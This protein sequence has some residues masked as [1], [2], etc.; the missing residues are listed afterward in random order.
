MTTERRLFAGLSSLSL[1]DLR[2]GAVGRFAV[3][4]ALLAAGVLTP[5]AVAQE[6]PHGDLDRPCTDCHV[7]AGNFQIFECIECHEHNQ[8]DMARKHD[9]VGGY[10]W[11]SQACLECHPDGKE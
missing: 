10:V 2:H 1:R 11:E 8:S 5:P 6:N 3:F 7:V 4:A 9:E